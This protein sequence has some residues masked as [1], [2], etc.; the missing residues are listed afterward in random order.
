MLEFLQKGGPLVWP[1]LGCSVIALAVFLERLW[2]LRLS[3]V[4]PRSL[5][6]ELIELLRQKKESDAIILCKKHRAACS[7][8]VLP[9]LRAKDRRR[10]TLKELLQDAVAR[11]ALLFERYVDVLSTITSVSPLLGLLG[12]VVGLLEVFRE[13]EASGHPEIARLSGGIYVAMITTVLGLTVAIPSLIAYKYV[14]SRID[15]S[16][17]E[18]EHVG[19]SVIDML[20]GQATPLESQLE[21]TDGLSA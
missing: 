1:I 2:F 18:I 17:A 21:T 6:I 12:T 19:T 8:I 14:S 20:G 13:I 9:L 16:L 3:N 15:S 5:M 4:N 11:Q 7:E 10:S